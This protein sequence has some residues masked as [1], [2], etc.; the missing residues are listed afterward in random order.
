MA[1]ASSRTL[2]AAPVRAGS[3]PAGRAALPRAAAPAQQAGR[4]PQQQHAGADQHPAPA[5]PQP[6]SRRAALLAAAAVAAA[7]LGGAPCRAAAEPYLL[8]TGGRGLLAEEEAKL[9]ELRRQLEGEVR[10]E[11]EAER[12]LLER[13]AR[14][15]L[16]NGNTLCATPFGV[17]IVGITEFVALV[18]ALVG[19]ITSR[20]RK[21]ELERLNEQLRKVNMSLR[22]QAR[23]GMVYAPGLT[24]APP[25]TPD[26]P[27]GNGY[28]AGRAAAAAAA[29][30]PA[31]AAAAAATA[32]AAAAAAVTIT[33]PPRPAET[34]AAA[35]AAA[36][37]AAS[38]A[39]A[40][41]AAAAAP[42]A[43]RTLLSL[44]EDEMS[45]DQI[46][47][48]ES[49]RQGK[50][51]LK[52]KN[53]A[54]ALVRFEKALMLSKALGDRV[55]ER[56]AM[57][58][59][60]AAA[61]LQGQYRAAI[62]HLERVLEISREMAEFTGDADAYGTIADCWTELGDFEAAAVNYDKYIR[63]M[64]TDGTPV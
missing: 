40:A 60:A 54:A 20:Q 26:A 19:G 9:V 49:L 58:G 38:P 41:A 62:K 61:R 33:A 21:A 36:A 35:A 34:P 63:I 42:A 11:I 31:A 5:A 39:A 24:Y 1:F 30:P 52:E 13:E 23:A 59:L 46:A 29:A 47:C 57:R 27:A 43:E 55:Q 16:E 10:R 2:P 64:N 17:D 12:E 50:R 3:R 25:A 8:S 6:P 22:Q 15:S 7:A 45:L 18:G 14:S 44:D 32:A 56:R 37:A 53:G 48:R 28:G 51:M 4:S